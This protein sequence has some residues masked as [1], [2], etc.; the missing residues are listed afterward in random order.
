MTDTPKTITVPV[1]LPM[2]PEG[3][4]DVRCHIQK[5][6]EL[7]A[8]EDELT[9]DAPTN[10]WVEPPLLT[11]P[12]TNRFIF[13]ARPLPLKGTAW[14]LSHKDDARMVFEWQSAIWAV[15]QKREGRTYF[16]P[17]THP[18]LGMVYFRVGDDKLQGD[19]IGIVALS[20]I[21]DATVK[22]LLPAIGA[23]NG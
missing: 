15:V 5:P 19:R 14:L 2:P 4:G 12:V 23:D 9:F 6:N 3:W 10:S 11:P 22:I 13:V 1:E 18:A 17:L 8:S 20:D 7:I 21:S 16:V